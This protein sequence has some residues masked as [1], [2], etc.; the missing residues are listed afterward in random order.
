MLNLSRLLDQPDFSLAEQ[1]EQDLNSSYYHSWFLTCV[2]DRVIPLDVSLAYDLTL[3]RNF[4]SQA[5]QALQQLENALPNLIDLE[6]TEES[7]EQ[8]WKTNGQAWTEQLRTVMINHRNMGHDWQFS[9]QQNELLKQYYNAN[10]F[11]L[12]CLNST[13]YVSRDVR[14]QIEDNLLLP[15]AEI[16]QR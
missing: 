11:L 9:E 6:E 1:L 14:S 3:A 13:C 15:I 4:N 2:S 7:L 16:K 5:G 8:W 12:E 10:K